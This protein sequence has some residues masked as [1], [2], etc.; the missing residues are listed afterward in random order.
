MPRRAGRRT[1]G[2]ATLAAVALGAAVLA[3][4]ASQSWCVSVWYPS[5]E[6]PG[7][8]DAIRANADVIDIVH[9][10]WYTPDASGALLDQSGARAAEQVAGW[11]AAGQLVLPSIF[12]GHWSYLSDELRPAHVAAIVALVEEHGY[13]GIDIDYEMFALETRDVFSTFVEE[14]ALALHERGRLLAVTVHAKTL[15]QSP[16]PSAAAQDWVRL[17]A[18]ADI[19]NLMTYDYTNRNEPPGPV[20]SI[21]WAAEVVEYALTT[22]SADEVRVGLPFYGYSWRRG[23]P[24]ATA[25]TWEAADRMITQFGLEVER[26]PEGHELVIELDVTG[27]PRQEL[28]VSDAQTTFERLVALPVTGGVAIW[29]I[30]GEDPANW[31]VLRDHRPAACGVRGADGSL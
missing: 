7:G 27:L 19:L 15:D 25:T 3:Q 14:L 12:A 1:V 30:G 24:P 6:H 20:A 10:F 26:D 11:Q 13:D 9:P 18:A 23:R 21:A 29:G 8:A 22:T 4:P 5:S 28:Y 16:F 17:A 2:L 31:Q